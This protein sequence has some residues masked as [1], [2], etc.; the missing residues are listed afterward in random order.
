MNER[1]NTVRSSAARPPVTASTSTA[2]IRA[3]A[4]SSS[5][6]HSVLASSIGITVDDA[7]HHQDVATHDRTCDVGR[8]E[9]DVGPQLA[10]QALRHLGAEQPSLGQPATVGEHD[11]R[12]PLPRP[13]LVAALASDIQ[14]LLAVQHRGTQLELP[15]ADGD[16]LTVGDHPRHRRP[17]R[18]RTEV[19]QR[20]DGDQRRTRQPWR[21]RT[22]QRRQH[23]RARRQRANTE[24]SSRLTPVRGH[25]EK[26]TYRRPRPTRSLAHALGGPLAHEAEHVAGDAAH[27]DLLGALGD[28]VAAVVAVDVLE[29]LVARVAE[30]AEAPASPGRPPRSTTGWPSSCT[31]T[32]CPTARTRRRCPSTTRSCG[33]SAR[34]ISHCVCSST[35]GNWIAWF[36]GERLAERLAHLGVLDRLVDAELRRAEA[37]RRLADPVLVEEVLDDTAARG[38]HHR[39]SRRRGT[40][41]SVR[42]M[43]AWSVG[44]LNVHRNSTISKPGRRRR[45]E[46][47]GDPVAVAGLA[48]GAGEDQVVLRLV[49]PGVPRL[50]AVDHPL[51]AVADG[52]G[53]HVR[54]VRAV[55]RLGDAE[56]EPPP[57][58]GEVVD[59]LRLL[60]LGAVARSSAAARR[61]CRRSSARS[62][63]RCGARDP[64]G[65][66]CSRI[67]AIPRFVPS[68]PPYSFGNG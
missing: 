22:E 56:R 11:R 47:G 9:P 42:R 60:L 67:I 38:P 5:R 1:G 4:A 57:A 40:R 66:K 48:A 13:R 28:A 15:A 18:P 65:A 68:C 52:G 54:R 2:S 14:S 10:H 33:S 49:D 26:V 25:G 45:H 21:M 12:P 53:L 58:L 31:S 7:P 51:V 6:S 36:V 41:M 62:A 30:P 39:R 27:L 63:G 37:R 16:Q 44:M 61:C 23:Q 19:E 34:S 17:H 50:L 64:C 8:A 32:P 3:V 59:P 55:L 24:A 35:S 29:R 46:E 20:P 43:W